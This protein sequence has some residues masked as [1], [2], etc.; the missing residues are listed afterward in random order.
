MWEVLGA[1]GRFQVCSVYP[2][3]ISMRTCL[4]TV[5]AFAAQTL[6]CLCSAPGYRIQYCWGA[7]QLSSKHAQ[8]VRYVCYP[9]EYF[10]LLATR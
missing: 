10:L 7:A 1:C 5:T 2:P 4:R 8:G 3:L 6:K 9:A